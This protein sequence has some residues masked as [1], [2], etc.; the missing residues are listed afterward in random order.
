MPKAGF[1]LYTLTMDAIEEVLTRGVEKIYPSKQELEK[2]LRSG[3]KIS[4]YNGIDPTGDSLHLGHLVQLQKLRRFQKLGHKV[5]LLIGDFTAQIGDP[6]G[7]FSSRKSLSRKEVLKNAKNYKQQASAILNFAGDNPAE[8][9]YNSKWLG[10]MGLRKVLELMS[11]ITHQQLIQRDM[12][13]KRIEEDNPIFMHELVYPILQG[14]DS[15][16]MEI[17]LEIG[18]SD[19]TFNMLVGRKLAKEYL[20]KEKFVLTTELITD[21]SGKKLGQSEGNAI[22]LNDKP[23]EMYGKVMNF[24]DEV[25][26]PVFQM[27]TALPMEKINKITAKHPMEAKKQLAKELVKQFHGTAA[28]E[29]GEQHFKKTIQKGEAPQEIPEITVKEDKLPLL[30]L[31]D[32]SGLAESRSQ[33]KR[34]IRQGGVEIDGEKIKDVNKEIAV[35]K[36]MVVRVGKRRYVG[37]S[38]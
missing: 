19:Q 26:K 20:N 38:R 14:Y 22:N 31:V 10:E 21:C 36:G 1:T 33:A 29:K 15:V 28:G 32:K 18:G 17:D 9:K 25:V 5:I 2:V 16:A 3:N 13:Q 24:A 8:L 23:E 37:V 6:T 7:K 12:F 30:D 27:C 35:E 11:H 4:L 34:L